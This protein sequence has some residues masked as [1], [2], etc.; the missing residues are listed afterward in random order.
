M[1]KMHQDYRSTCTARLD[2]H[3]NACLLMLIVW[4]NIHSTQLPT[5]PPLNR[6]PCLVPVLSQL[7]EAATEDTLWAPQ[8]QWH[9][10]T[11]VFQSTVDHN[12]QPGTRV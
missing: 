9:C 7:R 8:L 11:H 2:K 5:L 6:L 3:R 4:E 12:P 10:L 1:L